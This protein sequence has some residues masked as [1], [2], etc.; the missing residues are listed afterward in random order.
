MT[1]IIGVNYRIEKFKDELAKR[2]DSPF[3][4]WEKYICPKGKLSYVQFLRKL[5]WYEELTYG[6]AESI[7]KYMKRKTKIS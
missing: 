6:I 7:E 3:K 5:N 2:E 4:F 1:R